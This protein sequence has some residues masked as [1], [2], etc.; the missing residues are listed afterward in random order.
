MAGKRKKVVILVED[1]YND[2]EFWYPYYRLQ[3]AGADVLVAGPR[4]GQTCRSKY[5]MPVKVDISFGDVKEDRLDGLFVP[6]GYAPDRIRRDS[7]A[8]SLVRTV[9]TSGKPVA[10]ICHAGW[11]LISAGVLRGRKCT[12]YS[13]IRDDMVNAGADWV[14]EPVVVDGNLVS[15]RQPDDLPHLCREFLKL[16]K[17]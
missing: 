5:G 17:L 16:L 3:E 7:Y 1:L 12:S 13:A 4:E 6:G 9:F 10:Q 11:V 14:D 2:L 8:L 15:S